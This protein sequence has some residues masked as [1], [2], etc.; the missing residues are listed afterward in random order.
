MRDL[1]KNRRFVTKV[2]DVRWKL[3]RSKKTGDGNA[4]PGFVMKVV[5]F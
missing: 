2:G 5:D 1:P 4:T 3:G